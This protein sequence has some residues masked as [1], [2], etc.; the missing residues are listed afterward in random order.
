[1]LYDL[2]SDQYEPKPTVSRT[3]NIAFTNPAIHGSVHKTNSSAPTRHPESKL[4]VDIK[5]EL[6]TTLLFKPP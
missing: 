2:T 1:M 5:H 6:E 4:K 3:E